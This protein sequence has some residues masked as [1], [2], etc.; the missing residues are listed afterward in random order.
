MEE[1]NS[2]L[3]KALIDLDQYKGPNFES[4]NALDY[5]QL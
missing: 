4:S 1:P 2:A 5:L 3:V